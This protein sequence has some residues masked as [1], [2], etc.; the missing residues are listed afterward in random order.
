MDSLNIVKQRLGAKAAEV[1]WVEGDLSLLLA[2]EQN[3]G[4]YDVWQDRAVFH[5]LT[6]YSLTLTCNSLNLIYTHK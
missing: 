6:A 4:C 5:F 3:L 2:V 1:E